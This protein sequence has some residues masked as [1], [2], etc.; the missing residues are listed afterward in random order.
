MMR[1]KI[2]QTSIYFVI[3]FF[4]FFTLFALVEGR[5]TREKIKDLRILEQKLVQKIDSMKEEKEKFKRLSET[6][7]QI[8]R[9][10][11]KLEKQNSALQANI[12]GI[13]E[14]KKALRELYIHVE[15]EVKRLIQERETYGRN[16]NQLTEKIEVEIAKISRE[17]EAYKLASNTLVGEIRT[18]TAKMSKEREAYASAFNKLLRELKMEIAKIMEQAPSGKLERIYEEIYRKQKQI[19]K[20]MLQS[21]GIH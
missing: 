20:N 2:W 21:L 10:V 14:E 7:Q 18:A 15:N 19:L 8:A 11:E 9:Q 17:R 12:D 13:N 6:E 3:C 5:K 4:F 1:V 16:A